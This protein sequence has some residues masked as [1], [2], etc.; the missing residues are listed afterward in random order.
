[1]T[2]AIIIFLTIV[3]LGIIL[4]HST[5]LKEGFS[6]PP[7]YVAHVNYS[8]TQFNPI[9]NTVNPVDPIIPFTSTNSSLVKSAFNG[10]DLRPN[11]S[12]Y[13]VISGP[14]M[15]DIPSDVP[16]TFKAAKKCETAPMS[17]SAFDDPT[18]A[19]NCGMSFDTQ[20][21]N[22]NGKIHLGGLYVDSSSRASQLADSVKA[23]DI[24]QDPYLAFQPTI[25][26]AKPGTFALTKDDCTIVKEKVDCEKKQSFTSP[27]CT[28][29]Y[30]SRT[31]SRVGPEAPRIPFYLNLIGKGR[32]TIKENN[33]E[34][35]K[36]L[37][38]KVPITITFP[39][40][41]EGSS[42][43]LLV[44]DTANAYVSG[45]VESSTPSGSFKLDIIHMIMVDN[46]TNM[47][48]RIMGTKTINGVRCVRIIPG[49]AMTTM[50]LSGMI[51]FSFIDTQ[52]YESNTC[53]NGPIITKAAS[54]TFLNSDACFNKD[55]KPGNYSLECLQSRWIEMGG[56]SSGTGYP[57]DKTK[58]DA[59]QRDRDGSPLPIETIIDN[60][61]TIMLR[62][63]T[64][65]DVS[66][67]SLSIRDWNTASMFTTGTPIT[68]P[69][70]TEN[71]STG[72][73]SKECLS[74]LYMNQGITTHIGPTYDL[75]PW[76]DASMLGQEQRNTFCQPGTSLDPNTDA[77]F[78]LGQTL[79]GVKEVKQYYN[80][81]NRI[82]NDDSRSNKEREKEIQQCYGVSLLPVVNNATPGPKQVFAVGP[83]YDYTRD[84]AASVCATYGA[85]VATKDQLIDAQTNGADWCFS[86]WIKDSTSGQWPITT[87]VIGGCGGRQGIIE[88]TP[89]NKKAGVTCYG[90]KPAITTVSDGTIKPFNGT[91]WDQ[92]SG[93]VYTE[94]PTGYL[95]TTGDQPSC[96]NGFSPEQA[97]EGCNRLGKRCAGF[98]YSKDGSGGGCYKGNHN[99]GLVNDP[100]YMG[101]VKTP[102]PYA[103]G[104][105]VKGRYIKLQYNRVECLNLAE[106]QVYSI[107]GGPNIITSNTPVT[108]SS[109]Y[110]GD[111][112]PSRNFVDGNTSNFVH[113]SCGDVPWIQ[114]DLGSIVP[115]FKIVVFNRTDCCQ[116]RI[117]GT[118]LQIISDQN[119][120]IYVSD[121]VRTSNQTY[122]WFPPSPAI[123]V[124]Q[125]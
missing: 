110:Q 62:A 74:Y 96:F 7:E 118:I 18:F 32:I 90:S 77:G 50:N 105:L 85:E 14:E 107:N 25:G 80:N 73:L 13:D 43:S 35:I 47:K 44:S 27:N 12:G 64:G 23:H 11:S 86:A 112:Y 66:G 83:G 37:S 49:R 93:P 54:A 38:D 6:L 108:K 81:I 17:C 71:A 46:Q 52:D 4:Y 58:A 53:S 39:G 24:H 63:Q 123:I 115:I 33:T 48:P 51:P 109:G 79:G 101:Y 19:N 75:P 30:T 70:D 82:A 60:L 95:Q 100:A 113:S 20:G 125:P 97:Q 2:H 10:I 117:L 36:E 1:M 102:L 9:A 94:V 34:T 92:P 56:T 99:A 67:T 87:S 69:C 116:S 15:Y 78:K 21:T 26:T 61:S 124:D 120:I 8:A 16:D 3:L 91:S 84:Q 29:C 40:D 121:P 119:E 106:I 104:S 103:V 41:K 45:Y 88:W 89:D 55:N 42:F 31:F 76:Q 72:P 65:K 68:S 59:L 111:M 98:S 57:S 122:T 114:V 5:Y 28:Q 22:S